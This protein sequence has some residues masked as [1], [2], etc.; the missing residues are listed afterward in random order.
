MGVTLARAVAA[1]AVVALAVVALT[2]SSGTGGVHACGAAG[3]FGF[4]TYEAEDN[5]ALYT[6]AMELAVAGKAV[7]I[8]LTPSG[9][10]IDLTY[11]GLRSGPRD[12]RLEEDPN[13]RIPPTIYKSIAWIEASW[14][15]AN[16]EV[17]WGGV[18]PALRS[19]DCGYG[20]GQVTTGMSNGTGTASVK[21]ALVGSHF[22]FNVAEGVRILASKWNSDFRPIAGEGDPS[23][24]EDWY[25]A[26]WSYNGFAASNH[27]LSDT[28]HE[29]EWSDHPLNP[30][31][32]P[33]RGDVYHCWDEAAATFQDTGDGVPMFGYGDYTYPERV[34]GCMR[35]PPEMPSRLTEP[36]ASG[37]G[38]DG[39]EAEQGGENVPRMWVPV[40]FAMPDLTRPEVAAALA[41]ERFIACEEVNF[42][43]GCPEMD[44]P[45]SFPEDSETGQPAVETHR[46]PT[47]PVDSSLVFAL[48]GSPH[49]VVNGPDAFSL[50]AYSDGSA[51]SGSVTVSN[52]GTWLAPYRV[53][54]SAPWILV[55]RAG[56]DERLHGGLVVGGETEVVIVSESVDGVRVAQY[57]F[58]RTLVVTLDVELLPRG[59]SSGTVWI[60]PLY[61]GGAVTQISVSAVNGVEGSCECES[62]EEEETP[63][64]PHRAYIPLAASE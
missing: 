8:S 62:E 11:P 18:G 42:N 47:P 9:E 27:P 10:N 60:E 12:Q 32:D 63:L 51:D 54:T 37:Q 59:E 58:A 13:L 45:T 29:L 31:R 64:Y 38:H 30:F 43:T 33:L 24:L 20:L 25:Y 28:D 52:A 1:A 26:I 23:A 16:H 53:R 35:N 22:L 34:Y 39:S 40:E 5:V 61:G 56:D 19:F 41:P 57:G 49:L 48:L 21:Q 17:P 44:F 50:T 7:T 55:H 3:P 14:A 4:D 6:A 36:Q 15:Q 2:A 46:D